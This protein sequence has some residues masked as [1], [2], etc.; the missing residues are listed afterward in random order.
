MK[1]LLILEEKL[2]KNIFPAVRYSTRKLELVSDILWAIAA[3]LMNYCRYYLI[4]I[5]KFL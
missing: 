2:L 1:A 4:V 5:I 3:R